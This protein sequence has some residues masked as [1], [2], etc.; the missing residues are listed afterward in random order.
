MVS[1]LLFLSEREGEVG[2]EGIWLTV[3][4]GLITGVTGAAGNLGGIA[5]L[6]IARYQGTDYNRVIWIV[7][8]V[9]IAL[10]L[11]VLWIRP[12]PKH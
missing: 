11:G 7:G 4:A 3:W 5:Y 12:T 2:V 9:N 10:S 1:A 8:A 6:L